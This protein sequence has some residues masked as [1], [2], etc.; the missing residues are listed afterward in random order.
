MPRLCRDCCYFRQLAQQETVPARNSTDRMMA[1]TP[2]KNGTGQTL[3]RVRQTRFT[4]RWTIVFERLWP[5]VLPL[6][7]VVSLFVSIS[8]LGLFRLLPDVPRLALAVL[9]ALAA[10]AALLPLRRFRM[11]SAGEV[12]RRI[13]GANRLEHTPLLV[14]SDEPAGGESAF[15]DALWREHQKRMAARL[16]GI[17]GD[18]PR[19]RVPERDPWGLRSIAALLF[20]VAFAFSWSPISGR[21]NDAFHIHIA[22]DTVPPRIDAWITPPAYTSRPPIFLTAEN[23]AADQHLSVPENSRLTLRITGGAG[24]EELDFKGRDG[25]VH[26]LK[27]TGDKSAPVP[28][29]AKAR[30]FTDTLTADGAFSLVSDGRELN[31]WAVSVIP[32]NPP[33]I[34]FA[35]EPKQAANGTLELAYTVDD[36]Y[37]A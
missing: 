11:P 12:D 9:F 25:K 20:V 36:D 31:H 24:D 5:R 18:M 1:E 29:T 30:E 13:E 28:A 32:D 33:V 19:T 8:W 3:L 34:H 35:T 23:A 22:R 10:I 15:A 17:T 37:G 16:A 4:T 27:A 7:I 14:Q 26:A 21:L 6:L 2:S